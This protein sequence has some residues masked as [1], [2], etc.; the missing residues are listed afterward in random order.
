ME[1]SKIKGFFIKKPIAKTIVFAISV[2]LSGILASA[3]VTEITYP[4]GLHW[5][6]F[7]KKW[8]F[9]LI[10]IYLIKVSHSL[11]APSIEGQLF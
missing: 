3:F 6:E 10:V 11:K 9:W 7:Y 2:V 1:T 8:S 5:S 4:D